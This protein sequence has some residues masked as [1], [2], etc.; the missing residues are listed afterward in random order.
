MMSEADTQA[1]TQQV[2]DSQII[3]VQSLLAD[4]KKGHQADF[5]SLSSASA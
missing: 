5:K 4:V 2:I 1:L 3:T